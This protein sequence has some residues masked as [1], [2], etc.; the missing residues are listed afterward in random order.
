MEMNTDI[1]IANFRHNKQGKVM[2]SDAAARR[3]H[4]LATIYRAKR[5]I[6]GRLDRTVM[7]DTERTVALM[8]SPAGAG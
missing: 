4:R 5:D 8:K 7:Q 2:I 1:A 3:R 6:T